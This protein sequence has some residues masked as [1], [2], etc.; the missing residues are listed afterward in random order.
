MA[1]ETAWAIAEFRFDPSSGELRRG[2]EVQHLQPLTSRLLAALAAKPLQLVTRAEV[3]AALWPDGETVEYDHSI[4]AAVR[5]L[6][7]ALRDSATEPRFIETL[8]RRGFRLLVAAVAETPAAPVSSQRPS[9]HRFVAGVAIALVLVMLGVAVRRGAAPQP[10][11]VAGGSPRVAILPFESDDA[12]VSHVAA[13]LRQELFTHLGRL[14]PDRLEVLGKASSD[15]LAIPT[16]ES[17]PVTHLLEGHVS[18]ETDR[19]R[20]QLRLL[21]ADGV[22]LWSEVFSG[23][24]NE[25]SR[26]RSHLAVEVGRRLVGTLLD[27]EAEAL[28]RVSTVNPHAYDLY[29]RGVATMLAGTADGYR[30]AAAAFERATEADATYGLAYARLAEVA[31]LQFDYGL[32]SVDELVA[33]TD[34]PIARALELE[35]DSRVADA[36]AGGVLHAKGQRQAAE[37]ALVRA[38]AAAPGDSTVRRRYGWLLLDLDRPREALAVLDR[39][40]VSDPLSPDV[41]ATRA[42]VRLELADVEA[43]RTGF[44]AAARLDPAYPFAAYGLG[45]TAEARQDREEAIRWFGLAYELGGHA[46][47][48][49]HALGMAY[50]SAGRWAEARALL[51]E[52]RRAEESRYV[53]PRFIRALTAALA[54]GGG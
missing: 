36:V 6:R 42:Y 14:S 5:R 34:A 23:G 27:H 49:V 30:V 41:H 33:R 44:E 22:V 47:K 37:A 43:A 54:S 46:P 51:A 50:A 39:A 26:L 52:L 19:L 48:Y 31:L 24:Q 25:V 7:R 12:G 40:L 38:L 15:A 16:M 32:I 20:V 1:R 2:D 28:A 35:A 10:A 17:L 8:P 9:S 53:A 45:I 21:G 3:R 11:A 18:V 13:G 4:D 29:L